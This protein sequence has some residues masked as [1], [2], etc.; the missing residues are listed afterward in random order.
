MAKK[1]IELFLT[2]NPTLREA[3][4]SEI[5][6][7]FKVQRPWQF[8]KNPPSEL[9][10]F[11]RFESNENRNIWDIAADLLEVHGVIEADPVLQSIGVAQKGAYDSDDDYPQEEISTLWN[12]QATNF[13]EAR[14]LVD[15]SAPVNIK[16]GQLDTGYTRHPGIKDRL[17]P[18]WDFL[19]NDNDP[20]DPLMD[21][22]LL[23][24]PGHGTSTGSVIIGSGFQPNPSS[25]QNG[26]WPD[27]KFQS[28]RIARSVIHIFHSHIGAAICKAVDDGCNVVTLSMG[29]APPRRS[30]LE[31]LRYAYEKGV[32][33]CCAAGNNVGFVVW[34]ARYTNAIAV[35]GIN[36]YDKV[37]EG[38]CKGEDV[39]ISAPGE[40]VYVAQTKRTGDD[41]L[42]FINTY[43]SGTSYATPHV[44]AAAAMWLH[45]HR[46]SL[47]SIQGRER[48]D[49]FRWALESSVRVP[50]GWEIDKLGKGILDAAKLLSYS[51]K[52]YPKYKAPKGLKK[53][54]VQPAQKM[55]SS[56]S[57]VYEDEKPLAGIRE[58]EMMYLYY[59]TTGIDAKDRMK[60]IQNSASSDTKEQFSLI[61]LKV[62][63]KQIAPKGL[64]GFKKKS[65]EDNL[66][67]AM[68]N[69]FAALVRR[70]L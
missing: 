46:D 30:W 41:S 16:I 54:G 24:Q 40:N 44:A 69:H 6:T 58:K 8:Y 33:V 26:V 49:I 19:D 34:P 56:G 14:Q 37:W 17:N 11:F 43:G 13:L 63:E 3:C 21:D 47:E 60:L 50:S 4:L 27:V 57:K 32:I 35:A 55:H 51:P 38:S 68:E 10:R 61:N 53:V 7:K 67:K 45:H 28:Y 12:H 1:I 59:N 20:F 64:K 42:A 52:D 62:N 29:G 66:E 70:V 65:D 39:D 48:V 23:Q 2:G 5:A 15:K 31:A 25:I 22:K 36:V 18:G 9:A